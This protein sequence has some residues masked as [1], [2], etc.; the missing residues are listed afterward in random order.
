MEPFVFNGIHGGTG[1]Y[2]VSPMAPGD[3]SDLARRAGLD[4]TQLNELR[5]RHRQATRAHYGVRAGISAT[6]LESAGW[7]VIFA[8]DADPLVEEALE[9]LLRLRRSQAGQDVPGRYRSFKGPDGHRSGESKNAFLARH[10]VGPGPADPDRMPYYVLIVGDPNRIPYRFQSQLDVTYAVGRLCFDDPEGYLRYA[11]S[12][13]ASETGSLAPRTAAFFGVCND[14]DRATQLSTALLCEPL[15]ERLADEQPTWRVRPVTRADATKQ[16]LARLVG[17]DETPSLLFTAS[18]GMGF[19]NDD[20]RRLPHQGAL[21]CQ[22]WPGPDEHLGEVP[23]DWYF[24]GEDVDERGRVAGLICMH[25]ACYGA[26]TP[27]FDELPDQ[28]SSAPDGGVSQAFV[29]RLAQRLL[30]H[31]GGGALAVIG[32]VGPAWSCSYSW[33]GAGVQVEVFRSALQHLME[34]RPVGASVEFFNQRY[35]DVSTILSDE[36]ERVRYGEVLDDVRL[37][38]LWTAAS[39]ARNYLVIGDP[40]ARLRTR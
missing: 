21:L 5:R 12:V 22:D 29:A 13:V 32:H 3:L 27:D 11:E 14:G 7:G 33:P 31:P 26:G 6:H 24:A 23:H 34:G 39:D 40:A 15:A 38:D 1:R 10:G 18:H 20:P 25:F 28:A 37:A 35:A 8:D 30:A 19:A 36:L 17:G 2:L 4:T 9:P 16:R